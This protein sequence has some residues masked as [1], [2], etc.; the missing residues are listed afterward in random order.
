VPSIPSD[1]YARI[2]AL[3]DKIL[4]LEKLTTIAKVTEPHITT[5]HLT[6]GRVPVSGKGRGKG[7][8]KRNAQTGNTVP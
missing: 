4:E 1:V 8:P 2:K 3:E 7:L 5:E 6:P